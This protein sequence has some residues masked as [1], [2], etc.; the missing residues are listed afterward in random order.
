MKKKIII[1]TIIFVLLAYFGYKGFNLFYY[2]ID[3]ITIQNYDSFKDRLNTKKTITI[4]NKKLNESDYLISNNI[5]IRNDFKNYI[6]DDSYNVDKF[7]KYNLYDENNKVK[8][9]FWFGIEDSYVSLLKSNSL[10]LFGDDS[11]VKNVNYKKILEKN[12]VVN[13]ID[14]INFLANNSDRKNNIFTPVKKMR[15]NYSIQYLNSIITPIITEFILINGD[16]QGYILKLQ[17]NIKQV[18]ILKD[19][20]RYSFVFYGSE[21]DDENYIIDLISTIIID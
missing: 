12:N 5:K 3:N 9:S 8:S 20:K 4:N 1:L 13:D 18:T 14:L 19:N 11:K 16:Y 17:A 10:V 15:E 6:F 21:F 2:N 7:V